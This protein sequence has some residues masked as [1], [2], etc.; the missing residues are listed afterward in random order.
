MTAGRRGVILLLVGAVMIS[1]SA[2]FVKLAPVGATTAAFWRMFIGGLVL[3]AF[4]VL[5]RDRL[6][7]GGAHLG[8]AAACAAF[9]A[10]DLTFWHRSIYAVGP[11]LATILAN[12]QVIF[13]GAFGIVFL[14]ERVGWRWAAAI[15]LALVGLVFMVGF[16]W[17]GLAPTYKAGVGF[18]LATAVCY[19]AYILTLKRSR[20]RGGAPPATVFIAYVSLICAGVL[21][22]IALGTGEGLALPGLRAAV[23]LVAYAVVAQVLGW[24]FI[25]A[26][27]AAV[28]ATRVGLVLLLQ[29]ALS[30]LW[31]VLFFKRGV[32]GLEVAGAGLALA[33]IYLG[34]AQSREGGV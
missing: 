9:F 26:G 1:F 33:A 12:F 21:A 2:V 17:G 20:G 32:G 24:A 8:F 34:T 10:L 25:A 22:V 16:N 31:D 11:G 29:P 27:I 6:R 13:V 18:G 5:R 15:P 23:P 19:S 7:L 3:A 14:R 30:F 4:V 28:P